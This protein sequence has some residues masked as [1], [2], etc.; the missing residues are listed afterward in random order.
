MKVLVWLN[1]GGL[2]EA[3]EVI[4][5]EESIEILLYF[6]LSLWVWLK[7]AVILQHHV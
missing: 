4:D 3:A 5:R 1:A 2:V 6:I 7:L